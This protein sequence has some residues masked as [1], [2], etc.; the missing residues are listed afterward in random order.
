MKKYFCFYCQEEVL[1]KR[2]LK[3]RFCPHC[4]HLITD[5]GDGFYRVCNNCGANMT[6][7]AAHCPKC[8]FATGLP[9]APITPLQNNI[10]TWLDWLLRIGLVMLSLII[11]VGILYVSFYLIFAVFVIGL[12]FYLFNLFMPR[13]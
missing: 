4:K 1:P 10:D 5:N 2:L 12:A 11:S 6:T 9:E 13:R 7:D 8:G 3:W